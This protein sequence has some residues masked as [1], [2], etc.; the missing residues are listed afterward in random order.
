MPFP[1]GV[2]AEPFLDPHFLLRD[3]IQNTER[4]SKTKRD[5][6]QTVP[7]SPSP[8]LKG[9]WTPKKVQKKRDKSMQTMQVQIRLLVRFSRSKT[10]SPLLARENEA[11][12]IN[13]P[14]SS[15]DARPTALMQN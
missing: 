1:S 13:E 4:K 3:V 5:S 14:L 6:S 12:E 7:G 9:K 2:E 15:I 10:I 11:N 8:S